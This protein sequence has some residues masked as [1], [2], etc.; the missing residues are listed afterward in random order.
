MTIFLGCGFAAK[1]REGGGNFSVPL[2]W[3]LGLHRLKLD[4]IWLELLPA[5]DD[6]RADQ[7]RIKNFQ[8]QLRTHGLAGRYCLLYQKPAASTHELD[9]VRCIGMSKQV[10]L[11]RLAGPNTLLNL[12][13]SIHPPF[14]L[15]FERRIF[16]DLDPSEIFYWMTKME[17][18]QSSHDEFWTIGLNAHRNDCRLPKANLRWKTFYPLADTRLL[19]SQPRPKVS[20]FTTIGQWYWSG[21][22]EVAGEFPD[23]SKRVMFEP[24]LGLPARVPETQFELAM[25]ISSDDPER[26]RLQRLGWH[27]VDPHRVACTPRVYRRYMGSALAEFTAIKGVDVAWRTGWLSDRAAAFLALGRPVITED[28]GATRYLPRDSGF[29][30]IRN[31]D[32]AETAVKEVLR[33]WPRLSKQARAC[34]VEVFDS[35]KNLR[36]ILGM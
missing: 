17:L 7:A 26:S 25:N 29:R 35:A 36:K 18:G 6:P 12:S 31:I 9:A 3:M 16:C 22:V 20:K 27:V 13:Y 8:R 10:L 14:L 34:A 11:N 30:F 28:T 23:L 24:Y 19:Q 32:E 2:Q 5:T 33:D 4:A 1:Y 15:Q 21:A